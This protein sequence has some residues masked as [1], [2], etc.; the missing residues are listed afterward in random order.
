MPLL[1]HVQVPVAVIAAE[2][3]ALALAPLQELILNGV[4]QLVALAVG[5]AA[6]EL[7]IVVDDDHGNDRAG[8]VILEPDLLIVRHID[9]VGDAHV[10]CRVVRVRA[11]KVAV[12]LVLAPLI[13]QQLGALGVALEQPAAGKLRD[14][15]RD[16]HIDRRL[17]PAADI[18]E[19]PVRPDDLRIRRAKDRHRQREILQ[20]IISRRLRIISNGFDVPLE[21]A[22]LARA[23]DDRV[24]DQQQN[25][26][27]LDDRQPEPVGEQ[28][29]DDCEYDQKQQEHPR[30]RHQRT[31]Q[32][33]LAGYIDGFGISHRHTSLHPSGQN[34][35]PP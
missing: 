22:A 32:L 14:R 18:K 35:L 13:L 23:H 2:E 27:A 29:R 28:K 1:E 15:V 8:G 16:A 5:Q 9:P 3:A 12:D 30:I 33:R 10:A 6:D 26:D 11:H 7:V 24:D 19:N 20:G 25:D 31:L 4:A 17:V 34:L 21:C